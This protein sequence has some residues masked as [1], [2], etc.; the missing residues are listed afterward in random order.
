MAAAANLF[1]GFIKYV[2]N[3][4]QGHLT[5]PCAGLVAA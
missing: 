4:L 5:R 1:V 2:E 3:W